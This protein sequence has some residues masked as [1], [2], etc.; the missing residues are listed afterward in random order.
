MIED[1]R[2]MDVLLDADLPR[3]EFAVVHSAWLTLM[4]M[5][6]NGDLDLIMTSKL[7]RDRF[8]GSDPKVTIG[9]PGPLERRIRFQPEDSPYGGYYDAKGIDDAICK[10]CFEFDGVRFIEPRFYFEFK[11]RRMIRVKKQLDEQAW[12]LRATRLPVGVNGK[13]MKKLR[14]DIT[15]F[16]WIDDFLDQGG[17]NRPEFRHVPEQAWGLPQRDWRPEDV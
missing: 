17:H 13:L 9:L 7:R 5:R 3:G 4:G 14:K 8:F 10:R 1:I 11:R 2:H 12:W 16:A 6:P 15:D